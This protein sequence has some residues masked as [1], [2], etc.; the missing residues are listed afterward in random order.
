MSPGR[1][2]KREGMMVMVMSPGGEGR[3]GSSG[4]M[5]MVI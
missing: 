4:M 3:E 1:G 5:E 2:G